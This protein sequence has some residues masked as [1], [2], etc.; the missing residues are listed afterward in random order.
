MP[1]SAVRRRVNRQHQSLEDTRSKAWPT[2]DDALELGLVDGDAELL[3]QGHDQ[4][5]QVQAVGV[6]VVGE[7]GL[8]RHLL[9]RHVQHLDGA[10]LEL[11]EGL[12]VDGCQ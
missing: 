1:V 3:L 12:V 10:L 5:D 11:V 7:A 9:G 6:E 8:E 4:L 2:V